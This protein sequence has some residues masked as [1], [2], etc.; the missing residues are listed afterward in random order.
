MKLPDFELDAELNALR[1]AMGAALRDYVSAPSSNVLTVEEIER[2]AGEGI[3]IPLDEVRVLNDGTHVYKGRRVIVYIRDVAEYGSRI[4]M[5]KY[6]LAMCDTLNK[7][8]EEGRYKKRYVV[9]TREDGKFSIQRIRGEV[10]IRSDE[11]LDVCQRCLDELFYKSFSLQMPSSQRARIV[12]NFSLKGFFE[13]YGK[14]CVWAVPRFDA[15]HAPTN[16][17]STQFYRI[18]KTLKEKRGYRCEEVV[19]RIELS[20]PADRRFL[21]AHHVDSDKSDNHPTNIRLLCIRCHAEQFQHSHLRDNPDYAIFC[22]KF[23]RQAQAKRSSSTKAIR[24]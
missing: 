18:A 5:P 23:P 9:A 15:V 16:I 11:S 17:Y 24:R 19:C 2:L 10:K 22:A 6:H 3:E 7:M 1:A 13:E 20:K 12:Q 8:I 4:S 14:S 21:H